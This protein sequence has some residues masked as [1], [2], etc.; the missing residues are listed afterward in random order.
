[1]Q[2]I[3]RTNVALSSWENEFWSIFLSR[4]HLQTILRY[5]HKALGNFIKFVKCP[6]KSR[7]KNVICDMAL[8]ANRTWNFHS[9][10]GRLIHLFQRHG[11]NFSILGTHMLLPFHEMYLEH[12]NHDPHYQLPT[13]RIRAI[14]FTDWIVNPG[15]NR[16][17]LKIHTFWIRL[18]ET[19]SAYCLNKN[20]KAWPEVMTELNTQTQLN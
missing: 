18:R 1:M 17:Y 3:V 4:T 11:R 14:N 16:I 2:A 13:N 6:G 12:C 7:S 8:L 20:Q 5:L 10:D 9:F 19:L 15:T